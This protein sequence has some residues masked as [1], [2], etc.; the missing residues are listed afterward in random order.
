MTIVGRN[1]MKTV[2]VGEFK[3]R[4]LTLLEQV[5]NKKERLIITKH[6][7]PMVEVVPLR[8]TKSVK[9]HELRGSIIYEGDIISPLEVEWGQFALASREKELK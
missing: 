1:V 8:S 2:A 4:C 9:D 5:R 7:R 3:A 6:G